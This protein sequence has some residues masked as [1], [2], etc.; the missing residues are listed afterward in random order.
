MRTAWTCL[1]LAWGLTAAAQEPAP[2]AAPPRPAHEPPP[3]V[4]MVVLEDQFGRPHYLAAERGDVIVLVYGDRHGAAVNQEFAT[5]LH[6]HFHPSAQGLA[7]AQARQAPVRPPPNWPEGAR[8]P[9]VRV[10]PIACLGKVPGLIATLFRGQY[11]TSSPDVPMVLDFEN[12]MRE[13]FGMAAG[14]TNVAVV[15]TQ[16]RVRYRA[17]GRISPTQFEQLT[18]FIERL[19][20]EGLTAPA[21]EPPPDGR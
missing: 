10:V 18:Q 6:V 1:A 4:P 3:L 15:D 21:A 16:G 19:R 7:P 8:P 11:R 13:Y 12:K 14:T 5:A 17:H 9:E 2:P 20:R